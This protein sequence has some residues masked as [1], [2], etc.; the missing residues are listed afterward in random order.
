[1][2]LPIP[3]PLRWPLLLA[4]GILLARCSCHSGGVRAGNSAS[5]GTAAAR[6][7]PGKPEVWVDASAEGAGE[8]TRA[9]PFRSLG[10]ALQS[11]GPLR[12]HLA[13]GRYE[14]PFSPG[15]D[16]ELV[17]S[18]RDS[19]VLTL[20]E[21]AGAQVFTPRGALTLESLAIQGGADGIGTAFPLNLRNVRLSGQSRTA[22]V[23]SRGAA[24]LL[25]KSE[26]HVESRTNPG[27][28]AEGAAVIL[29]DVQLRG[30]SSRALQARG[31]SS[32]KVQDALFDGPESAISQRDGSL[33]LE[34]VTIRGGDGPAIFVSG[35]DV[36]LSKV[37]VVGHEFA[38]QTGGEAKLRVQG[39]TSRGATRA[40]LGLVK[41][42]G[43]LV[44]VRIFE[45]GSF[46]GVQVIGSKLRF[47]RL[48]IEDAAVVGLI[49]IADADV[50]LVSASISRV[51]DPEGDSGNGLEVRRS[52]LTIEE[53]VL[54]DVAGVGLFASEAST[55]AG[56][57]L[58]VKRAR[59]AAVAAELDSEVKLGK[60]VVFGTP[61]S[62]LMV[63]GAARLE[64]GELQLER[65]EVD[66]V[67]ADCAGGANVRITR[68]VG[69][70]AEGL[71]EPCV[72]GPG[73]AA[74]P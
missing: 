47:E 45:S 27:I 28:D 74:E 6:S 3:P 43:T 8:G 61:Q 16:V 63:P 71:D 26:L 14:G 55:V 29:R 5:P 17:G 31:R 20:G 42:E 15:E 40:A 13:S 73:E 32:V 1:M 49:A 69:A 58:F 18:G 52:N 10:R 35:A 25:E 11:K 38:L 39:L 44:D 24:L 19:T 72:I 34:R 68:L 7:L 37:E 64:V 46:G 21:T 56:K 33:E 9:S 53:V 23:L 2:R 70:A 66:P 48:R 50:T 67:S 36:R 51:K 65:R 57:R 54:E 59:W 22:I 30:A 12:I 62:A 41:S 4:A 60:L